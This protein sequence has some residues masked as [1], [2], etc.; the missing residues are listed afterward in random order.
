MTQRLFAEAFSDIRTKLGT[1][2]RGGGGSA[3]R[4]RAMLSTHMQGPSRGSLLRTVCRVRHTLQE[5]GSTVA[6][7]SQPL[8][9]AAS[10]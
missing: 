5:A 2:A 1:R 8:A 3:G 10:K 4:Y 6:S 7:I 9:C